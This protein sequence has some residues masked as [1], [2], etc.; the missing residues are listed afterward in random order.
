V[1]RRAQKLGAVVVA[2]TLA[3]SVTAPPASLA[4][5]SGA[6]YSVAV[7]PDVPG[8]FA[9]PGDV[10]V[11]ASGD[12]YIA[13]TSNCRIKRMS[14]AGVLLSVW[15]SRGTAVGQ[16][17]DPQG[18]TVLPS[19]RVLVAD[20]GNNRLQ[21]FEADGTHVATW[22]GPGTGALQFSAPSGMGVDSA[23]NAYVADAGNGRIQK[24]SSAG[25]HLATI[26]SYGPGNGELDNPRDV[27]VDAA[28]NIYVADT[29]NRRIEKFTS[30]GAYTSYWGPVEIS[31]TTY[32][33]YT[34][35]SGISI[36]SAGYVW[37]VDPGRAWVSPAD[38][39]SVRYYIERCT[40]TGAGPLLQW[41]SDG[42]ASGQYKSARG[43]AA[44]PGGGVYVADTGNNRVQVVSGA[45]AVL[46]IWTGRGTAAG[47]LDS[48]QGV[49]LDASGQAFV[50]DTLNNRVQVFDSNGAFVRTFG[51]AGSAAGQF[52]RPT[53]IA[54]TPGGNVLVVDRGNNR[55]QTFTPAGVWVSSF[56]SAG[57]GNAQFSAPE[58]IGLDA[59]GNIYVADTG[60]SRVQ[61]FSSAWVYSLTIASTAVPL[62]T[63]NAPVD[64]AT[65]ASNNIYLLD[66]T[67]AQV[68]VYNSAGSSGYLRTIGATGINDGQFSQP[69]GI[70]VSGSS[71]FV[72]DSGNSR[73][74]RLTTTGVF[75]TKFGTLGGG[76]GELSW[77][78]RAAVDASGR[79]LVAE[80]DNHR[81]QMF[82]YDGTS[83]V[84]TL[85]GFENF[86]TYSAPVTMTLAAT[87]SGSGVSITYFTINNSTPATV[88]TGPVSIGAEGLSTIRYWSV[89]RTGNTEGTKTARVTIDRIPPSGTLT[90]A[91]GAEYVATTT[92]QATSTFSDAVDMR[93]NTDGSWPPAYEAFASPVALTL[94]GEGVRVV[95]AEYRDFAGNVASRQD[96]VT[97]DLTP[98]TSEGVAAPSG[99]T[100]APVTVSLSAAD[101]AS[102]LQR[103]RYRVGASGE[104]LTYT[105]PFEVTSEGITE[106]M[107][108]SVDNVGNAEAPRTVS[109]YIDLTPPAG[110][111]ELAG[112]QSLVATDTFS[113]ASDVPD[114][115][116]MR[117]DPGDGYGGWFAYDPLVDTTVPHEGTMPVRVEYRDRA[118]NTMELSGTLDVDLLP[119]TTEVQGVI[120]GEA[121]GPVTVTLVG[122]D[123]VSGVAAMYYRLDSG[124][125]ETY[126]EPFVVSAEGTTTVTYWAEDQVGHAEEPKSTRVRIDTTAPLG[127]FVLD[128]D[129]AYAL[130]ETVSADSQFTDAVDMGFDL[131][132]GYGM[133]YTYA[134]THQLVLLGEGLHTVEGGFRDAVG[135]TRMLVDSIFVD[136]ASPESW[137]TLETSDWSREPVTV[138]LAG[139]DSGSGVEATYY[140]IGS[141]V[142]TY[143]GAF[144]VALEGETDIE[145]WS[146]DRAGRV[147]ESQ[148][149]LVR[150]DTIAPTG[151][152]QLARGAHYA[153]TH[154][155]LLDSVV[156]DAVE[157][158]V[159][160]GMGYG[161]W[162]A[163]S[164]S[165]VVSFGLDGLHP[166]RVRYRDV[167]GNELIL[168]DS[169]IL[170]TKA[171]NMARVELKVD[172][173]R[174]RARPTGTVRASWSATDA[175]PIVGYSYVIDRKA[176]TVPD[177]VVDTTRFSARTT[178]PTHG[179]WYF[180]IRA[181]DA[182]GRWSTTRTVRFV[183]T[184]HRT[185]GRIFR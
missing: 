92:V 163:Y 142:T 141:D 61:K 109:T 80:R 96:T 74:Q 100:N 178:V 22:G 49:A 151:T 114:A 126:M 86:M 75:E 12:V 123:A 13:D 145:Y 17:S 167:A 153:L 174:R 24:I 180:H 146:V 148:H 58:G 35:P 135:N 133:W 2:F 113:L 158:Q 124:P 95:R 182:A 127:T 168:T 90:V 169:V 9:A 26:G 105:G 82:S 81:L 149:V 52:N 101:T 33:R 19:G 140:R 62:V 107:F 16:F 131:G 118:G 53:D 18:V 65:D 83:P 157:M 172:S 173:W 29:N 160:I 132:S 1:G 183:V 59:A 103:I 144:E 119:P 111:L 98:P 70:A 8:S 143:T 57:A 120:G 72:V 150:V 162:V 79:V 23:G 21:L 128:G 67:R 176:H 164:D 147:E 152:M 84:T 116:D 71:I 76:K 185:Y 28:G 177:A 171:P 91:G 25:V 159:D 15:G 45:G 40:N 56:G 161:P 66:R 10:S 93:F 122:T 60:N 181:K 64:V 85:S 106:V 165:T 68:R 7:W 88:Y 129:A 31:G 34:A 43:I 20:T 30:A 154:T 38:P 42:T 32:S 110:T 41:G 44:R 46:A 175:S 50:A 97:V 102:G 104:E 27:A 115:V 130:T 108:Y 170:D 14:S 112:G 6:Y 48:P 139:A 4:A 77:P 78:S 51:T 87:D 36:D 179:T 155:V 37:V 121:A 184:S 3:L 63:V 99:W 11:S 73:I 117:V 69:T 39:L 137:A 47:V 136:L 134:T 166:V 156:P 94:P 125:V 89:D 5:I 55:V 54:I 138:S